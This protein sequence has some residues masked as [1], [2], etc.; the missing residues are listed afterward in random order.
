MSYF[1]LSTLFIFLNTKASVIRNL[2]HLNSDKNFSSLFSI[3][4]SASLNLKF[5]HYKNLHNL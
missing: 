3:A 2:N 5:Q 4:D 1:V